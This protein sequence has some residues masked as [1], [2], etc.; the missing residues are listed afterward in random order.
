MKIRADFVTKVNLQNYILKKKDGF[1][2]KDMVYKPLSIVV[3]QGF[4]LRDGG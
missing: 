2:L 1:G 3:I 4:L